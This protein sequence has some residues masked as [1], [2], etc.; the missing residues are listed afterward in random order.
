M[1]NGLKEEYGELIYYRD[2]VPY[3]AGVIEENGAIYYISS[4]GR[5]VKGQ[6]IVHGSMAN[7]ILERGTYTFGEDCKLIPG[8][9]IA[10]EVRKHHSGSKSKKETRR[11]NLTMIIVVVLTALLGLT[12]LVMALSE[13]RSNPNTPGSSNSIL[14]FQIP[15]IGDV[16]SVD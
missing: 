16:G 13:G 5:A 14:D 8:S 15:E 12:C 3:H 9:F 11:S 1:T 6:H 7:G 4:G 2:G 10:P